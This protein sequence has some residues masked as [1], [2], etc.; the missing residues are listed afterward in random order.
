VSQEAD[1]TRRWLINAGGAAILSGAIVRIDLADGRS[2]SHHTTVVRGTAGNP[3]DAKEV[4]AKAFDLTA[5]VLGAARAREL[6]A[7]I[8]EL[9]RVGQV[10]ELRRLLQA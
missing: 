4:E 9:E 2:L 7:A 10:S 3:M 8:G 5:P 6:I 1:H